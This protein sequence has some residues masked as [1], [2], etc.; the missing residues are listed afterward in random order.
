MWGHGRSQARREELG[1]IRRSEEEP[2]KARGRQRSQEEPGSQ[3]KPGGARRSQE[4]PREARRS[5][6]VR[7]I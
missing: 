4:E 6:E 2:G 3:G 5:E 1:K 7:N